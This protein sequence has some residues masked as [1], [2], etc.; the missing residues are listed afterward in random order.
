[1][2]SFLAK[3]WLAAGCLLTQAAL[4]QG[5]DQAASAVLPTVQPAALEAHVR[6]LADDRLRGRLPG[7]PG[8][9][10]AVDYVA[11]QFKKNGVAPAGEK[12]GYT[13]KVRLRRAFVEPGATLSHQPATGATQPLAYGPAITVYP[14]PG[15]P[16]VDV[17]S[18]PLVFAGYGISAPELKYDD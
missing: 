11:A 2:M 14:N 3:T 13:Q 12:G 6:Y 9:Q 16:E 7:T 18:A 4:A 5:I 10:M 8:Y 17:T 1:M 15:Q